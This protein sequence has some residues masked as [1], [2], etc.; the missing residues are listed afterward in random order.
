MLMSMA[1]RRT[2]SRARGFTL[3]ELM[4]VVGIVGVLAVCAVAGYHKFVVS[5]HQTEANHVLS[6]IKER[7]DFYKAETGNYM[8]ISPTLVANQPST[9]TTLYPHC[10]ATGVN[11]PGAFNVAWPAGG[12]PCKAGCCNAGTDWQKLDVQVNAPTFY[13]YSTVAGLT[14]SAPN[15]SNTNGLTINGATPSWPAAATTSP[16]WFVATA[17]GD[18]DG[19]GIFSTSMISSVDNQIYIDKDGE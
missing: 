8:N 13:G 17:L 14:G 19:N 18:V 12:T 6:G 3:I 15:S 10:M 5:S 7:Q 1:E 11:G 2:R 16:P 9:F 4:I